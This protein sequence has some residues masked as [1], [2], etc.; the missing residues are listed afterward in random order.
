MTRVAARQ[1]DLVSSRPPGSRLQ[2]CRWRTFYTARCRRLT[3]EP[4]DKRVTNDQGPAAVTSY[5]ACDLLL[6]G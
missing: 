1:A 2:D 3:P 6:P 5:R 4:G